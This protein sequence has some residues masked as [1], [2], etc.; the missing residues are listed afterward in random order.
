MIRGLRSR[1]RWTEAERAKILTATPARCTSSKNGAPYRRPHHDI[2]PGG[3]KVVAV[4]GR[5]IVVFHVDGEFS[6]C[7]TLPA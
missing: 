6:R 2:P 5:D 7:S 1:R 3:N 4:D